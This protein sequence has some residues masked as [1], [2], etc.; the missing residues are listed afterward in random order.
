M[1]NYSLESKLPHFIKNNSVN[2]SY[3]MVKFLNIYLKSDDGKLSRV[4]N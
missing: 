1:R 4:L 3:F 2:H